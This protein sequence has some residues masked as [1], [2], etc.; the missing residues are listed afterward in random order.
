VQDDLAL[1]A[2]PLRLVYAVGAKANVPNVCEQEIYM[3]GA[4]PFVRIL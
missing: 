2:L 4:G 1:L 3:L